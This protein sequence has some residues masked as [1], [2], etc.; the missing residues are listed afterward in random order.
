MF[1]VKSSDTYLFD[2]IEILGQNLFSSS[3]SRKSHEVASSTHLPRSSSSV[4]VKLS[5]PR[6]NNLFGVKKTLCGS[7]GLPAMSSQRCVRT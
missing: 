7:P 1:I 3:D 4:V 2:L 6:P 5:N